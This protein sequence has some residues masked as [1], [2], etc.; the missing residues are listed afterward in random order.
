MTR[1]KRIGTHFFYLYYQRHLRLIARTSG[2]VD[3]RTLEEFPV[4]FLDHIG[5]DFF[6]HNKR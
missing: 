2:H 4:Q 5:D 1:I 3:R 6:P